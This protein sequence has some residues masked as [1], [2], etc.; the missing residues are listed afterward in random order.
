MEIDDNELTSLTWLH[1]INILPQRSNKVSSKRR[2]DKSN[3]QQ[4][5]KS[6]E[7]K[8]IGENIITQSISSSSSN[9]MKENSSLCPAQILDTIQKSGSLKQNDKC[10]QPI[11]LENFDQKSDALDSNPKATNVM[12]SGDLRSKK[13][14][15][16]T[17]SSNA[18]ER[19]GLLK[20]HI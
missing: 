1:S 14:S 9:K 17:T 11:N 13:E 6:S 12:E 7:K 8:C 16:H 19:C 20:V 10:T 4:S 5:K 15:Y 18:S 2:N 3:L